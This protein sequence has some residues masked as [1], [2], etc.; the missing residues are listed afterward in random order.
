MPALA[1]AWEWVKKHAS[2]VWGLLIALIGFLVGVSIKKRPVIVQGQ[3]P[4]KTKIEQETAEQVQQA[5]SVKNIAIQQAEQQAASVEAT[6]V[7][8]QQAATQ[9]VASDVDQTNEYL[10]DVSKQFGGPK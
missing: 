3:D 9:K 7:Q 10:Q 8:Q 2:L 6:I 4:D 5:E 1:V